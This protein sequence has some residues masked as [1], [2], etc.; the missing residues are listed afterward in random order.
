MKNPWIKLPD[1]APFV[2]KQDNEMLKDICFK[3][4]TVPR[5]GILPS[6]YMGNPETS[7]IFLLSL[8]PGFKP[9]D[10][11]AQKHDK[12]YIAEKRKSLSF[13]SDYPWYLLDDRFE[14]YPGYK[15]WFNKLRMMIELFDKDR[16]TEKVMC[17]QFIPY[18]SPKFQK[19]AHLP[20]QTYNFWLLKNAMS[21]KKL[22]I[23]FRGDS[24]WNDAVE[25]LISYEKKAIIKQQFTGKKLRNANISSKNMSEKEWDSIVE[26]LG[27]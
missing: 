10:L 21:E 13:R 18:Q 11:E 23:Q 4:T 14:G 26:I 17:L 1:E 12:L 9:W 15:W 6:P 2:L 3:E 20:S 7:Q 16:V 25:G 19:H 5:L 22:I 8:N 27:K 24:Y